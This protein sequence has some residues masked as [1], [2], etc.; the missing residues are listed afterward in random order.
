MEALACPCKHP[1]VIK[2]LAI[3]AK[4]MEVYILWWNGGTFPKMLNYNM[5]YSPIMDNHILLRQVGSDMEGWTQL[6]TFK[7]NCV[8]LAWAFINIMNALH[9]YGI[10]HNDLSKDHIMLHFPLDKLDVVYISIRDWGELGR[11]QEVMPS[12]YGFA[13]KQYAT[14]IKNVCWC[15]ASKLFFV[16][17][18]L[19]TTN[20]PWRMAKP[21]ATTLKFE[22]YLVGKLANVI[23]GDDCISRN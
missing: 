16:Y 3:H 18:K 9:H 13:M 11:L 19:G 15:V 5:K 14:I 20:S 1:S 7:Q 21:N 4:T 22:T 17:S 8:K 12:L 23:W 6:V 10:S 2:S